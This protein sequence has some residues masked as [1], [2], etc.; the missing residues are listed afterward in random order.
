MDI[1]DA[2]IATVISSTVATLLSLYL[3]NKTTIRYLNDQL[4]EIIKISI[5]YP[6]LES[7]LFTSKWD[8]NDLSDEYI[9]YENYCTLMFNFLERFCKY[10]RYDDEKIRVKLNVRSWV[11]IHK[12]YWLKPS[13]P[14]D[15][16]DS[17]D[18]QFRQLIN[19]YLL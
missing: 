3:N 4:D 15:N 18:K 19:N 1:T 12:E 16:I 8:P 6:Y 13:T 11:R 9:R 14:Y 7:E 17:Y 10:Y 2:S 5:Q